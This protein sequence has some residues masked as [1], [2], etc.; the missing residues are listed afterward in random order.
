MIKLQ[1]SNYAINQSV[2]RKCTQQS[3]TVQM[4]KAK[5]EMKSPCDISAINCWNISDTK[6]NF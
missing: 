4:T 1:G 2:G 5:S 3:E 6:S